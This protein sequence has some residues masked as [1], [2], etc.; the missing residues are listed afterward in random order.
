M[1]MGEV[2]KEN[3]QWKFKALGNPIESDLNGV[4]RSFL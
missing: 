2:Y 1:L 4:V 3:G